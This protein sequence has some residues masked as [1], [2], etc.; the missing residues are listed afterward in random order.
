[1]EKD[2]PAGFLPGFSGIDGIGQPIPGGACSRNACRDL[3]NA[4]LKVIVHKDHVGPRNA[5]FGGNTGIFLHNPP[6][7]I[8]RFNLGVLPLRIIRDLAGDIPQLD[9]IHDTLVLFVQVL[10]G[11]SVESL[12]PIQM[13]PPAPVFAVR[14]ILQPVSNLLGHQL[15]NRRV[16]HFPK[17]GKR[18][19][20]IRKLGPCRFDR[21]RS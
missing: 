20:P 2:R 19:V 10:C 21:R 7:E 16:F 14:H 8:I 4:Q 11:K 9:V 18:D 6:Q 5:L 3:F 13:P 15:R 1:M 12:E 17:V